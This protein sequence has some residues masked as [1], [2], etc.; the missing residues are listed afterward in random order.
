MMRHV[1]CNGDLDVIRGIVGV[2]N[3]TKEPFNESAGGIKDAT[4]S[5]LATMATP[6]A[7][8]PDTF[9]KG[10]LDADLFKSIA[11]GVEVYTADAAAN[12]Q[13]AGHQ[14]MDPR[15][16]ALPGGIYKD[17]L[18]N[19]KKVALDKPHGVRRCTERCWKADVYMT[20]VANTIIVEQ[21]SITRLIQYSPTLKEWF[22]SFNKQIADCPINGG[23]IRDLN[24]AN[25]RSNSTQKPFGRAVIFF[26]SLVATASKI[27]T[28]AKSR[29]NCA[30][31][32]LF[33][34]FIDEERALQLSMMADAS[35]ETIS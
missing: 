17:V 21:G 34:D 2:E 25:H 15:L 8:P 7:K 26:E 24:F 6:F 23:A 31:A 12:E 3:L 20:A 11:E 5:L 28:S 18:P 4:I 16:A 10:K 35:D 33:L 14:L 1:S 9:R 19:L 13:L 30:Y 22:N 29:A 27:L 32:Q